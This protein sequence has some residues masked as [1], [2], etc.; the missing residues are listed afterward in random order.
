MNDA[1]FNNIFDIIEI[2]AGAYIIYAGIRM[3]TT[4]SISTQLVGKDVDVLSARDPKG[5][6]NAMFP[7]N[8]LC[9]GLFLIMGAASMY[10][11][12]YLSVPLW[13]NLVIT[14]ALLI[15][16]IIFAVFTRINERKFL[17]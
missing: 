2:L 14:G 4:G 16:C 6:I 9:G 11:D 8:L 7:V 13:I 1:G 15:T 10:I 12:N 5:F 17:K 3:K